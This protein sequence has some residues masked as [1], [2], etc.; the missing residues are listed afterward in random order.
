[1][2]TAMI[3]K[4]SLVPFPSDFVV[5]DPNPSTP[6]SPVN[7]P[8]LPA[9]YRT[10]SDSIILPSSDILGFLDTELG[11]ERLNR[12]HKRLTIVGRPMPPRGLHRQ[13]SMAREIVVT[14]RADMHLVWSGSQIF[15][16]PLPRYL[17]NGRFWDEN[18]SCVKNC[19]CGDNND[20]EKPCLERAIRGYAVGLL[21]SYLGLIGHESDFKIAT[22]SGLL[23]TEVTW[24]KWTQIA[25]HLL[26]KDALKEAN[27]R[28]HYGEL[29]LS[30]LNKLYRFLP[31]LQGRSMIRG[32]YYGY[33][34]YGAFFRHNLH[35]LFT[36]F[37]YITVA[38]TAMQVGLATTWLGGQDWFQ[39]VSFVSAIA[40]MALPVLVLIVASLVFTVLFLDNLWATWVYQ[41]VRA[42]FT[43]NDEEV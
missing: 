4:T 41:R 33:N 14:E 19:A 26:K 16:K 11:V 42:V 6:P 39:G 18:L 22:E 36:I 37:A 25:E 23:P 15:V 7:R 28:Y 10:K 20:S 32:Y 24:I 30:R 9:S 8:L 3:R 35:W 38:L 2:T 27:I 21:K 13:K 5:E 17:L 1:M 12:I 29:R 40:T 31:F 43:R 34:Q